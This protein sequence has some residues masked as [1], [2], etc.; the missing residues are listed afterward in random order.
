MADLPPLTEY[1]LLTADTADDLREQV[2]DLIEA[3]DEDGRL[4][5]VGGPGVSPDGV[6]YQAMVF[7]LA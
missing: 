2:Q 5:P 3:N 6:W 7:V 4:Q 1:C